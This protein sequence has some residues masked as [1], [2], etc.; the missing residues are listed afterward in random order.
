MLRSGIQYGDPLAK[1][2]G[3]AVNA[4]QF[5]RWQALFEATACLSCV[6]MHVI[7]RAHLIARSLSARGLK[8]ARN[9]AIPPL[10]ASTGACP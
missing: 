9:P 3:I 6:G 2:G 4:T 7:H 10:S 1:N 8:H 5:A